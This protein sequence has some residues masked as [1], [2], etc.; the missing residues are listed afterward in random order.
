[1]T[2]HCEGDVGSQGVS[3]ELNDSS[4]KIHQ[5]KTVKTTEAKKRKPTVALV[6]SEV[7]RTW[8]GTMEAEERTKLIRKL[9]REGIGTND[10]EGYVVKQAAMKFGRGKGE[11]KEG[12]VRREMSD[13]LEDCEEWE[14][15]MRK[16][17]G[18]AR[19]ELEKLMG[20]RSDE[21]WEG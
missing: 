7:V 14:Q 6:K 13:K 3:L 18:R 15:K 11:R 5:S 16:D 10:V 2:S 9:I 12:K 19:G 8:T 17:R 4:D 20:N 21:V 1:M